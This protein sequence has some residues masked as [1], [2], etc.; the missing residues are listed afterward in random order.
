ME[1]AAD[2]L[3]PVVGHENAKRE[4]LEAIET[5]KLHHGWLLRGPRGVGKA[6]LAIQFAAHLLGERTSP[7]FG[8]T[9][10]T[11]V[12]RLIAAGSHPDL[13]IIRRP[14]DDKGREKTDIP[15]DSVR[16]LA[17]FF[18]LR[19]AM[20]GWRVAIID[21]VDELNR[22]GANAILKTLEEP[23]HRA[24]LMLISHGEQALLPTIRSRCR[25][26]RCGALSEAETVAA[27]ERGGLDPVKAADVAKIAPGRPGRSLA[28]EGPETAAAADAVRNALRALGSME[29]RALQS[30][31]SQASRSDASLA[32]AMDALR[33]SLQKRATRE[34]DPVSAGDWAAAAL[35]VMRL[36]SE[37]K[38]I[39]MDRAQTISA[40]LSRV[41]ELAPASGKA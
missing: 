21:A 3:G 27:L 35:D 37:A 14:V 34:M 6:R 17:Q 22:F 11:N 36:E 39:N 5:G 16:E 20:G 25:L 40:A 1:I 28:L 33:S 15:V 41:A 23:P 32:A 12:G 2:E 9:A 18:S 7:P 31:L 29:A 4:F 8:V 38:A 10:G 26:L 30:V 19:P 13:R 24:V